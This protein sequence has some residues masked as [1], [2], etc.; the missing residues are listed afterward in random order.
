MV[1][2][3][4]GPALDVAAR[5]SWGPSSL[6]ALFELLHKQKI[7]PLIARRFPLAE[8]KARQAHESLGIQFLL[9]N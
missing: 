5:V 1:H 6:I 9:T 3:R 8:A 4:G 2:P 7:K